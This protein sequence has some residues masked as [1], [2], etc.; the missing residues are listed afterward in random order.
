MLSRRPVRQSRARRG[1]SDGVDAQDEG[2]DVF[3]YCT[4]NWVEWGMGGGAFER[5]GGGGDERCCAEKRRSA[6][7]AA[8]EVDVQD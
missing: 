8:G 6:L 2:R 3:C 4:G 1:R 7:R 5:G